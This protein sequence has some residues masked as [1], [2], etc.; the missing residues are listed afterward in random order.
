MKPRS[1]PLPLCAIYISY[2]SVFFFFV[3][4][5]ILH[6]RL[7]GGPCRFEF[8]GSCTMSMAR[9]S[10]CSRKP[11]LLYGQTASAGVI[12]LGS[13]AYPFLPIHAPCGTTTIH[14]PPPPQVLN[15]I[16][17]FEYLYNESSETPLVCRSSKLRRVQ[18]WCLSFSAG[19]SARLFIAGGRFF[20]LASHKPHW[21]P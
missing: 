10:R 8:D 11:A 15:T 13:Y 5:H 18:T 9:L 7:F 12:F 4:S 6:L 19:T 20:F 14:D 21:C 17:L 16:P 1:L 2:S 3:S